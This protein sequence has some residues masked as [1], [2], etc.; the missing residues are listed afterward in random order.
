MEHEFFEFLTVYLPLFFYTENGGFLVVKA[1]SVE[2]RM[3]ICD[4]VVW[5]I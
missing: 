5:T 1:G 4:F 3:E 2:I